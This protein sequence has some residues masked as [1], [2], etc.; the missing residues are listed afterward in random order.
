MR[1]QTRGSSQVVAGN[2]RF[3]SIC[4][5]FLWE[6]LEL[7]K[8]SQ[9]ICQVVRGI[10]VLLLSHCRGIGPLLMFKGSIVIFLELWREARGSSQIVT[11]TSG[12]LVLPQG[13]QASFHVVRGNLGF[14]SDHCS[15]IR[16]HLELRSK[17]RGSSRIAVGVLGS[18][19]GR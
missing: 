7:S 13:S 17:T 5:R 9:A 16:P 6:T 8:G 14:L 3:L 12:K 19:L 1:W 11:G 2:L 18:H 4:N 15:G 10:M